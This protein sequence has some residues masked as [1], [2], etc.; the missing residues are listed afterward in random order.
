[1]ENSAINA[2]CFNYKQLLVDEIALNGLEGIGI[3]QLWRHL[4]KR[5]SSTLTEKMKARFWTFLVSCEDLTFYKLPEPVTPVDIVDRFM[6]IDEE[7]GNLDDP[8]SKILSYF[9]HK[10]YKC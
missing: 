7:S 10:I 9:Q 8:V 4:E 5:I 1:M 2:F 6:I 3:E